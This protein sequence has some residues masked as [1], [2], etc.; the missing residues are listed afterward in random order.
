V[1]ECPV[2]GRQQIAWPHRA[3]DYEEGL[4]PRW[5]DDQTNALEK[6]AEAV[7]AIST[8]AEIRQLSFFH[9][10]SNNYLVVTSRDARQDPP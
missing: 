8:F 5:R 2:E 6:M 7:S 4:Y 1:Q 10:I 3:G 9:Y